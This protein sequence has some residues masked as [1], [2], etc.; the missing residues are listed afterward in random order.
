MEQK[1]LR[2]KH[3]TLKT[4]LTNFQVISHPF[5]GK[6]TYTC[7]LTI[8]FLFLQVKTK[9]HVLERHTA[10]AD[11]IFNEAKR[12]CNFSQSL[13][14][15]GVRMAQFE[16]EEAGVRDPGQ[17][18]IPELAKEEGENRE[19]DGKHLHSFPSTCRRRALDT[20]HNILLTP[21]L[22]QDFKLAK[23]L[24]R[25]ELSLFGGRGGLAERKAKRKYTMDSWI[26]RKKR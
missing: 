4:K 17:L 13:R 5:T 24:A 18:T 2:G 25:E 10:S 14:L 3:L 15:I 9:S 1:G 16:E 8:S 23:K 22:P 26:Q 11:E 20:S 12:L 19:N 7:S 21:P 6:H